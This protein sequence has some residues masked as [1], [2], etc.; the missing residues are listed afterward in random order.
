MHDSNGRHK[1]QINTN[2]IANSEVSIYSG[3]KLKRCASLPAQKQPNAYAKDMPNL[4]TQR[5]SSVE[6]LGKLYE[7]EHHL[8]FIGTF[9]SYFL[10]FALNYYYIKNDFG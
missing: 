3:T 4:K 6:S 9:R 7:I 8:L 10:L 1:R 2:T 5:E